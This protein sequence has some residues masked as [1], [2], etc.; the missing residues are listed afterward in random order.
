[1][2]STA[3]FHVT[4]LETLD[5][6]AQSHLSFGSSSTPYGLLHAVGP[7]LR[8]LTITLRLPLSF[9][10]AVSSDA[11]T[12][13]PSGNTQM[14]DVSIA[15]R[16]TADV[17]RRDQLSVWMRVWPALAVQLKQLQSL[18]LWLDHDD[19][20]SWSFVDERAAL[21]SFTASMSRDN[22]PSLQDVSVDLPNL[23][24]RHEKP[25]RHFTKESLQPPAYVTLSRRLRQRFYCEEAI[26]GHIRVSYEADFPIMLDI[27]ELEH[28]GCQNMTREELEDWERELWESGED[29]DDLLMSVSGPQ[30][31]KFC[32]L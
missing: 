21:S 27:L 5:H 12:S 13:S 31:Y 20:S 19:H 26:L 22:I 15:T 8:K 14:P 24:P 7:L 17:R 30:C 2:A 28:S 4:D 29:V 10:E 16:H 23:H 1:M 6:L 25:E 9:F 3:T 11:T 32:L 18:H